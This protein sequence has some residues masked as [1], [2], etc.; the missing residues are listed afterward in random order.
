[1]F[2]Y[3]LNQ[4]TVYLKKCSSIL[5]VFYNE[6]A[7][8]IKNTFTERNKDWRFGKI[9]ESQMRITKKRVIL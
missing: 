5:A 8:E 4:S 3:N 2:T 9:K 1:M 7:S 6:W